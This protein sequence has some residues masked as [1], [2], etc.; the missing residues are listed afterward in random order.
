MF[1]QLELG[2]FDAAIALVEKYQTGKGWV[3]FPAFVAAVYY[4]KGDLAKMQTYWQE[5]LHQFTQK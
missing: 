5:Y 4:R 2:N 1:I 3:D